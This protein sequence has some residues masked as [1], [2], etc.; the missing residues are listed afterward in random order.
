MTS[1]PNPDLRLFLKTFST[2]P[3]SFVDDLF[4]FHDSST[5][6]TDP[7]LQTDP[8]I[9]LTHVAKWLDVRRDSILRTLRE[10]YR[11]DIDYV[12][13]S[14]P[15]KRE[16]GASNRHGGNRQKEVLI[17]PDC[18]KRICMLTRSKRGEQVRTYFIAL[19][20]LIVK[21]QTQ[22]IAGIKPDAQRLE[23]N[24]RPN[25]PADSAGYVYV[26]R[27]SEEMDGIYKI[28]RSKDLNQR[29]AQYQTGRADKI[30]VVFKYRTD[31]LKAVEK[32]VQALLRDE[33]YRGCKTRCNEV[34]KADL[35][36]IKEIV[37]GC[38]DLRVLKVEYTKR[39]PLQM[40]GGYYV[41]LRKEEDTLDASA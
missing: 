27:A 31:S 38:D 33:R 15:K 21:Y 25:D 41:V 35:D 19:E 2:V 4:A 11:K 28:G 7:A 29:L 9:D 16:P 1:S 30:E 40:T 12:S 39:K 17:T 34:Y 18:F 6:Q 24:M 37:K 26:I 8:V 23:R 13:R 22:L 36:M 20:S 3:N 14:S 10:S 5:L 32:C